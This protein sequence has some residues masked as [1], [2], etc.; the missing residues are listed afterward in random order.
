MRVVAAAALA[1]CLAACDA[2][3]GRA[4]RDEPRLVVL[5]VIDQFPDWAFTEKLPYL[6]GGFARAIATGRRYLGEHPSAV[7][8]TAPGHALL[9][10]G[11]PPRETGIIANDWWR[12]ALGREVAAMDD[13]TGAWTTSALRVPGLADALAAARPRS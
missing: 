13:G 12:P 3:P 11:A 4:W 9:G 10:T 7:T 8:S 6:H 2:P 5:V 1:S